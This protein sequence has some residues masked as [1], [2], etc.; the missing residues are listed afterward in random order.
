M[1]GSH[2]SLVLPQQPL[3]PSAGPQQT[4]TDHR[5]VGDALGRSAIPRLYG[6]SNLLERRGTLRWLLLEDRRH[7]L[8]T[9]I[10]KNLMVSMK[11]TSATARARAKH[12]QPAPLFGCMPYGEIMH[13]RERVRHD[14]CSTTNAPSR[15]SPTESGIFQHLQMERQSRLRGVELVLEV[16]DAPLAAAQHLED[17]E[18]SRVGGG[19]RNSATARS[20]SAEI[21]V[22]VVTG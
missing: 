4:R 1:I 21:R 14:R 19:A 22:A 11:K 8:P 12:S 10:K 17:L 5:T 3:E 18:A 6:C 16:A 7:R 9:V 2:V 15:R 13:L 20:R